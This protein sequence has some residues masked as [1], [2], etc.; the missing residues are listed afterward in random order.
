MYLMKMT[1]VVQQTVSCPKIDKAHNVLEVGDEVFRV[2]T[3]DDKD[4]NGDKGICTACLRTIHIP[5]Q[6]CGCCQ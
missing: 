3:E 6:A 4:E 1:I 5:Y 2:G